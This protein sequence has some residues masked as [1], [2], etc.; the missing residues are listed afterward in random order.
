MEIGKIIKELRK[1]SNLSQTGLANIIGTTQDTISLWE[2]G[3]SLPDINMLIK[4]AK[5]FNV[6]TDYLLGLEE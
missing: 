1:D 2:L 4:L 3:K 5:Y 6:S